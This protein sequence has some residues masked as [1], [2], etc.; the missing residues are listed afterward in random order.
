M[1]RRSGFR[2]R[3][4]GLAVAALMA[5][6][7]SAQ[8]VAVAQTESSAA[9]GAS[10]AAP[11]S[12]APADQAGAAAAPPP[13]E[14]AA[15]AA[16]NP[17]ASAKSD[18]EADAAAAAALAEVTTSSGQS[19]VDGYKLNLYGFAD[20][21][22]TSY[23]DKGSFGHPVGTFWVG[24]FNLY[25]SGELGDNW[26]ALSEVRFTYLPNGAVPTATTFMTG[27]TGAPIDTTVPDYTDLGRPVR[28]GGIIIERVYVERTFL[29]WLT[30]RAG[31]FLTPYGIWNV[32]H[33]SPVIIG[34][35]RPF[36]VGESLFPQSQTG[37]EAFG[38]GLAGPVEVG[39]HLTLSNGRGPTDTYLD[40]D[41][42]KA[43]GWRLW[44]R[45]HSDD[46]GTLTVGFSGYRGDYTSGTVVTA[47]NA[48]NMLVTTIQPTKQYSELSL[49]GDLK[50]E[51]GGA[52]FQSEVIMN[53]VAYDNATRP[54]ASPF[55]GPPGFVPDNRRYGA[56]GLG[57]YRFSWL[58]IMPWIGGEYYNLG[59][60]GINS[61]AIWGGLNVR[62]TQRVVLKMQVTQSF[63]MNLPPSPQIKAL[64][65]VDFQVAWSF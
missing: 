65:L 10:G 63:L 11:P 62:P 24:N 64:G 19:E 46:F 26:R 23:F 29:S 28:W 42:N 44:G 5:G 56:Y 4:V 30:V 9:P 38:S 61:A 35:R 57:G 3:S 2:S 45:H 21:A 40:L 51:R 18:A 53:D 52:L 47:P 54:M 20:M 59:G 41:G 36:V 50:W 7:A 6:F 33:G 60:Q 34:V 25:A 17:P 1:K 39:Y 58:G 48:Q 27:G 22:Y 55:G 43:I 8:P 32:D 31:H 13:A 15:P 49:G 14:P 12:A 16:P 37:L